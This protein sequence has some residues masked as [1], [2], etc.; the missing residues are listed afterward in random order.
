MG[1]GR[2]G[3][4]VEISYVASPPDLVNPRLLAGAAGGQRRHV[5]PDDAR[6]QVPQIK[7]LR[8]APP[9]RPTATQPASQAGS[10]PP[11][12]ASPTSARR[13]GA[14]PRRR[15]CGGVGRDA[16]RGGRRERGERWV[17]EPGW[18]GRGLRSGLGRGWWA[19]SSPPPVLHLAL[20]LALGRARVSS[21]VSSAS[22]PARAQG[23]WT[24][25]GARSGSCRGQ[26]A[27]GR[28]GGPGCSSGV[29]DRPV[30]SAAVGPGP[31]NQ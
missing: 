23:R 26:R 5:H 4:Q 19:L 29:V 27:A 22:A 30:R 8:P 20:E 10:P 11:S 7:L 9:L 25:R 18:E 1:R 21:P 2:R 3:W 17:G 13:G 15:G 12:E 6:R 24:S 16:G 14:L 31:R 28:S